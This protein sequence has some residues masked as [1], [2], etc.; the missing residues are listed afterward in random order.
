L[1]CLAHLAGTDVRA[2]LVNLE[3]LWGE[4]QPQNVPGTGDEE[5]NWRRRARLGLEGIVAGEETGP[6][7]DRLAR[8]RQARRSA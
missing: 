7:L 8:A 3:D 1:A 4:T 6:A 2:V 5:P